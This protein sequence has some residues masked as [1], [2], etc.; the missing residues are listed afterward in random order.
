MRIRLTALGPAVLFLL[1]VAACQQ[2]SNTAG[3]AGSGAPVPGEAPVAPAIEPGQLTPAHPIELPGASA[4]AP[5]IEPERTGPDP[6]I[7]Y[8]RR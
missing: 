2:P 7:E 8:D 4:V 6:T 3:P 1:L 5:A